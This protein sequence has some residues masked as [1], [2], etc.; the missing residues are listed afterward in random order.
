M[1]GDA[2]YLSS[3][4]EPVPQG[5]FGRRLMDG[6]ASTFDAESAAEDS[7]LKYIELI[8]KIRDTEPDLFAALKRM[9]PKSRSGRV[10]A[11]KLVVF[12][13]EGEVKK[14]VQVSESNAEEISF[15]EA[16]AALEC[17]IGA[18]R[19]KIN[20]EIYFEFLHSAKQLL[21]DLGG[22]EAQARTSLSPTELKFL[23]G[24]RSLQKYGSSGECVRGDNKLKY[25][26]KKWTW[27]PIDLFTN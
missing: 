5:L 10:G 1:G 15:L 6:L 18:P 27:S 9:P 4:E 11:E 8:R 22:V 16:A 24:I 19:Q 20:T 23:N 25:L 12:F 2:R 17:E 21:S 26:T 3:E 14:F 13:R 7:E